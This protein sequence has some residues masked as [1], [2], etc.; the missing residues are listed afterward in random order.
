MWGEWLGCG[1]GREKPRPW[2]A[3]TDATTLKENIAANTVNR[4]TALSFI[5]NPLNLGD[6]RTKYHRS[7]ALSTPG[8][9]ISGQFRYKYLYRY[10]D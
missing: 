8:V 5:F 7:L 6:Y 3:E 10:F 4:R 2:W 1:W 9:D